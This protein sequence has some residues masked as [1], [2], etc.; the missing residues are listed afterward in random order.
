MLRGHVTNPWLSTGVIELVFAFGVLM[1]VYSVPG[2]VGMEWNEDVAW[3]YMALASI[4]ANEMEWNGMT[5]YDRTRV[6]RAKS[7]IT[8]IELEFFS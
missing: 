1:P 7:Q 5:M 3:C 6:F 8:M 2:L 4:M